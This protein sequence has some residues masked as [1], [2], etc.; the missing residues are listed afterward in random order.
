[1]SGQDKDGE[2]VYSSVHLVHMCVCVFVCHVRTRITCDKAPS[3]Q[4]AL[5]FPQQS[6]V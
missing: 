2:A 6:L 3:C 1:M 4:H 5:L